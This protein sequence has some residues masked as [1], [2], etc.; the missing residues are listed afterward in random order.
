[1]TDLTKRIIIAAVA[2]AVLIAGSVAAIALIDD[3]DDEREGPL[4]ALA[5]EIEDRLEDGGL[6]EGLIDR[7]LG[8]G[9]GP[10]GEL[11]EEFLR[12]FGEGGDGGL[13]DRLFEFFGDLRDDLEPAQPHAA[14]EPQAPPH[15]ER[16]HD[17]PRRGRPFRDQDRAPFDGFRFGPGDGPF[18]FPFGGDGL[19]GGEQFDRFLEDGVITPE[20]A[21]ELRNLLREMFGEGYGFGFGYGPG[22]PFLFP[23][24]PFGDRDVPGFIAPFGDLPLDEFLADGRIS[25]DEAREL[26]RLFR[27]SVPGGVFRF[28]FVPPVTDRA[29]VIPDVFLEGLTMLPFREFLAD[30]ELSPEERELLRAAVNEWLDGLFA[31]ID[32]RQG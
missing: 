30:G 32:E 6:L 11:F 23:A 22:E 7:L 2:A 18:F 8:E 17:R 28:E 12:R 4:V 24:E 19:F 9:D 29:Q 15:D 14:P 10:S 21:E 13:P 26:E 20:E 3:D 31:R 5:E 25:P 1:M 27:E 16:D